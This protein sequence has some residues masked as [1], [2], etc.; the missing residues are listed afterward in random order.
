M[1]TRTFTAAELAAIGVPPDEPQ[2]VQYSDVLLADEHVATLKYT[3]KR[4]CIFRAPDD[5]RTYAVEYETR[6][7]TG[8]YEV[9]D[10]APDD[11]G[12]YG[13]TVEAAEVEERQVTVTQWVPVD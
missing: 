10:Y 4:R 13:G 2:D 8:D 6:L 1:P 11:H 12:W 5:A 7:D 9:G 3:A